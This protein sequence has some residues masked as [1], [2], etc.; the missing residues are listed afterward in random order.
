MHKAERGITAKSDKYESLHRDMLKDTFPEVWSSFRIYETTRCLYNILC[1]VQ[2][3]E[4]IRN[5]FG[6]Q[7]DFL[8][9][10]LKNESCLTVMKEVVSLVDG[11]LFGGVKLEEMQVILMELLCFCV[12][13]LP[14]FHTSGS[15]WFSLFF[16]KGNLCSGPAG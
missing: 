7:L 15:R 13:L 16:F 14:N 12:P 6:A 9:A 4:R 11:A 3:L 8:H 5:E 10:E 2:L 1:K